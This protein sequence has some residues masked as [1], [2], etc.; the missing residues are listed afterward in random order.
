MN[1]WH[2]IV[3]AIA[4]GAVWLFRYE[5]LPGNGGGVFVWDRWTHRLCLA[6]ALT[7]EIVCDPGATQTGLTK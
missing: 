5:P 2:W 7:G 6:I 4:L 1:R 3:I